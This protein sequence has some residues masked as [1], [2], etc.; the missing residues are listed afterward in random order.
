MIGKS[1]VAG[2]RGLVQ[3]VIPPL[4]LLIVIL[5]LWQFSVWWFDLKPFLVP[6]PIRVATAAVSTADQLTA[7]TRVSAAAALFGFTASLVVGVVIAFFFSQSR[8]I[9]ISC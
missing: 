7:A 8:L 4:T 5:G 3:A 6:S 1:S 2:K 9:R